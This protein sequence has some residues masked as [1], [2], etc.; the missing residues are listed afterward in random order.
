ML[1]AQFGDRRAFNDLLAASQQ[2][3]FR[4]L[5]R[6]TG[7]NSTLSE[8]LLQEVFLLIYRKLR[9]LND[10]SLYR[11]W[12]YRIASRLAFKSL[13]KRSR[14]LPMESANREVPNEPVAPRSPEDAEALLALLRHLTPNTRAVVALHYYEGK[15]LR[16]VAEILG[17]AEGTVKS[18][19]A[20]A[21]EVLRRYSTAGDK[22]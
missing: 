9:W 3:L 14:E 20:Y 12:V 6:L 21:L 13:K 17:I 16:E 4:Y 22:S 11:P 8:E 7:G 10:P 2:W 19:L 1:R 5:L 15:T 18:R